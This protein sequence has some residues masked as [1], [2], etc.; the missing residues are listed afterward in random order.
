MLS[1][2]EPNLQPE[3]ESSAEQIK[4]Y[5]TVIV[6]GGGWKKG[7]EGEKLGM[8]SKI[9]AL[10]AGKMFEEGL[11]TQII[12]AGGKTAGEDKSSLS[13]SEGM[14]EYLLR[15]FPEISTDSILL[16]EESKDTSGNAENTLK[17]MEK[18]K[19]E[20]PVVLLTSEEHIKRA[21]KIFHNYGLDVKEGIPAEDQLRGRSTRHNKFIEKLKKSIS[22]K[23]KTREVFLR[24][25]LII[26][27]KG[28][29]PR[30]IAKKTRR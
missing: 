4:P 7:F 5:N 8:D 20:G 17:I 26:D 13:E 12:L 6:L 9:R 1:E 22:L 21:V 18:Y 28:R 11:V 27:R 3:Q 29:I 2:T 25:L 16:E 23:D 15:K 10:A 24:G 30:Y 14:Q 19:I